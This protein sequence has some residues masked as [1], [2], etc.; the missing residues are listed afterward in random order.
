MR[1]VLV[2]DP[3]RSVSRVLSMEAVVCL[4]FDGSWPRDVGVHTVQKAACARRVA[5]SNGT[6]DDPCSCTALFAADSL[7]LSS[8]LAGETLPGSGWPVWKPDF[9]AVSRP[10]RVPP[11]STASGLCSCLREE[12][13]GIPVLQS[14]RAQVGYTPKG[15]MR[16]PRKVENEKGGA[17]Q[18]ARC[19]GEETAA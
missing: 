12:S 11:E 18:R 14:E 10:P 4:I 5:P 2:A 19:P 7:P 15:A 17:P 16:H 13:H 8:L 9:E 1:L 6:S 3:L